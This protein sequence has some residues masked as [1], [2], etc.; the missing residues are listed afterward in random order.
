MVSCCQVV[1]GLDAAFWR[2]INLE[3]FAISGPT[4]W[5]RRGGGVLLC[6]HL[7]LTGSYEAATVCQ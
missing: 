4:A 5:F 7:H 3:K 1:V 6:L 2:T